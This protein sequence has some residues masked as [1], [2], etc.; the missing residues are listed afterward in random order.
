MTD[1]FNWPAPSKIN[2]FLHVTGRR[3]D[4][5]HT[6]QTLF[7]FLELADVLRFK[8]RADGII[9]RRHVLTG[10]SES[11]DLTVRA[12]RLLKSTAGVASGV[13]IDLTKNIPV[14][15]GLGGGSS[16]AATVLVALN[17]IWG[18]GLTNEELAKLGLGLGADVP[19]FIFGRS[20]WAE[21]IGEILY[22]EEPEERPLVV[23]FPGVS[24][25][26]SKVFLAP[27]LTRDSAPIRMDTRLLSEGRND[28]ETITRKLYPDVAEA[29]DWLSAYGEARMSGT[30]STI[31]AMFDQHSEAEKVAKEIPTKWSGIVCRTLNRSP[32][33]DRLG[34]FYKG[35]GVL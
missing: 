35:S 16:D 32:L 2:R 30:G 9:S 22:E 12:A 10:V 15:G 8:L 6:I 34:V 29:L 18:L 31:F 27:E 3:S 33:A 7:Q 23:L 17:A 13:E 5:Y 28:C 14:G 11:D 25:A 1:S 26:T 21:G 4:G 19:V 20:S 24:V